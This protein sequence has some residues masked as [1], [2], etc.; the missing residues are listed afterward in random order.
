MKY[1]YSFIVLCLSVTPFVSLGQNLSQLQ[2]GALETST[3]SYSVGTPIIGTA[4]INNIGSEDA[5]DIY[6]Q[7]SYG[8]FGKKGG[9][10]ISQYTKQA[11]Q[12]PLYI[13]AG[14]K[15]DID[16]SIVPEF[17]VE[18]AGIDIV[19]THKNGSLLAWKKVPVT[20]TGSSDIQPKSITAVL[21]V[22]DQEYPLMS[23]PT[24]NPQVISQL[25][26]AGSSEKLDGEHTA[27]VVIYER[28]F[29]DKKVY[30][31]KITVNFV[32]GIARFNLPADLRPES[33]IGTIAL[34]SGD[35]AISNAI[36]F[37]Y[38]VEGAQAE[39]IE[40]TSSTLS[41]KKG[42]DFSVAI[43]YAGTPLNINSTQ[44]TR[45][46][47]QEN[48][49]EMSLRLLV[50]NEK[51]N[52]VAQYE[53]PLTTNGLQYPEI[54][55]EMSGEE[56][57]KLVAEYLD[58]A[59]HNSFVETVAL[60]ALASAENLAFN[61]E[62]INPE[63]SE[64]YD[65]YT[66]TFPEEVGYTLTDYITWSLIVIVTLLLIIII[67]FVIKGKK[68]RV[69]PALIL[70]LGICASLAVLNNSNNA[71]ARM[72][73]QTGGNGDGVLAINSPKSSQVGGYNPGESIDLDMSYSVYA[74]ANNGNINLTVIKPKSNAWHTFATPSV[75]QAHIQNN[76]PSTTTT[77]DWK[78]FTLK[79]VEINTTHYDRVEKQTTTWADSGAYWG[80]TFI[81]V[82]GGLTAPAQPG[83]YYVPF[84]TQYCTGS[85][86]CASA[87]YSVYEIC[88]NGAGLCPGEE[89][90]DACT[91]VSGIQT[92]EG[93]VVYGTD[94]QATNYIRNADGTCTAGA[95]P[96]GVVPP[97]NLGESCGCA[98]DGQVGTVQC[99][100]SCRTTGGQSI[101]HSCSVCNSDHTE[102][103]ACTTNTSCGATSG[104]YSCEPSG[105][106]CNA[107]TNDT[108]DVPTGDECSNIAGTQL[109]VPDGKVKDASGQCVDI[110]AGGCPLVVDDSSYCVQ[111]FDNA[112]NATY[113]DS[114]LSQSEYDSYFRNKVEGSSY[115]IGGVLVTDHAVYGTVGSTNGSC[116]TQVCVP[117]NPSSKTGCINGQQARCYS[118]SDVN[119]YNVQ[120]DIRSTPE[121]VAEG[122]IC[123]IVW[124]SQD[125][126]YCNLTQSG[127]GGVLSYSTAGTYA[128]LMGDTSVSV[129]LGCRSLDPTDSTVYTK[130][131]VCRTPADFYL[132]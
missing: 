23:G 24:I 80:D 72:A 19:V 90:I 82:D 77:W 76:L 32:D 114:G 38:V 14:K 99:D 86:G 101:P 74:C 8:E 126:D 63:T 16:F 48:I 69:V 96:A 20:V 56:I 59:A 40:I 115:Y 47:N 83:K 131:A 97:A 2:V 116:Q 95:C 119:P 89:D 70:V 28:S 73:L 111:L 117:D 124:T 84:M 118:E 54:T 132:R 65:S 125:T 78:T 39:I 87:Q 103:E 13:E 3:T 37:R 11:L 61:I 100:G 79:K 122:Q 27:H 53:A 41:V 105:W 127:G 75:A 112:G 121:F 60:R 120:L 55:E 71:E 52:V 110:A 5:V 123:S 62:L 93:G 92:E 106:V 128:I 108:C 66:T 25:L 57:N 107:N 44:N 46:I 130:Q 113:T 33:Y 129:T 64:V 109:T 4:T 31:E 9:V 35:R 30:D 68:D 67:R 49:A 7:V 50:T 42:Q 36:D 29:L 45:E 91:N 6:Y 43:R 58:T 34:T 81:D 1:I 85:H 26:L 10:L 88:V 17:V 22:D 18:G 51:G 104:S 15:I 94:N 21:S 102:G 12:G 98:A